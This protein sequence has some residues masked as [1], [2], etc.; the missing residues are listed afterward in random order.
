MRGRIR[1]G[2][3]VSL[4]GSITLMAD[5][6]ELYEQIEFDPNSLSP[7]FHERL[8]RSCDAAKPLALSLLRRDAIPAIRWAYFVEPKYN[9]GSKRSRVEIFEG[10]GTRGKEIL[11]HGH[12][13]EHLEYFIHGPKLPLSVRDGFCEL[14]NR[15]CDRRELRTYA[16][17]RI[18]AHGLDRLRA[19]EE[20]YK[21]ALE[22]DLPE[23]DARSVREAALSTR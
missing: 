5:E 14:I 18:R 9:V 12:F 4:P 10:N 21:L 22:C 2:E 17:N 15:D 8:T 6:Q 11:D 16:R 19:A 3:K 20:F 7:G 1:I 23:W 13:L